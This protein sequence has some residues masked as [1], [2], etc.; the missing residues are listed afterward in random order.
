MTIASKTGWSERFIRKEL[1]L[2]I[3]LQYYHAALTLSGIVTVE[4]GEA[5]AELMEELKRG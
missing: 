3:G 1:P 5:I 4:G 2:A